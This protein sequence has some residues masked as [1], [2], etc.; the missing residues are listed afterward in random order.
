MTEKLKKFYEYQLQICERDMRDNEG[1][2]VYPEL[3]ACREAYILL[4]HEFDYL[5]NQ[6]EDFKI[7]NSIPIETSCEIQVLS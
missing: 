3:V 6:Y 1:F 4:L 2:A 7:D 5:A